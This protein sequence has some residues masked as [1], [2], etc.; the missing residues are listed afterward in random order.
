M[1]LRIGRNPH[2]PCLSAPRKPPLS[3]TLRNLRD[4]AQFEVLCADTRRSGDHQDAAMKVSQRLRQMLFKQRRRIGWQGQGSEPSPAI[5]GA[6]VAL[7]LAGAYA[8]IVVFG[9]K[10]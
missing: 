3:S 8:A 10:G 5:I 6:L 1:R 2:K 7:L 4:F 9:H